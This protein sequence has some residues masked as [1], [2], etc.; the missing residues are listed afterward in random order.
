MHK[1]Y[2]VAASSLAPSH[3][4]RNY[5]LLM[6]AASLIFVLSE[7]LPAAAQN[8]KNIVSKWNSV[9]LN[10][11]ILNKS[12][13]FENTRQIALLNLS[14]YD[15]IEAVEQKHELFDVKIAPVPDAS[16]EAAAVA[17]GYTVLS[18]LFPQDNGTNLSS[19]Y[20]HEL[21]R[22]PDGQAKS[23]G[24]A[25]GVEVAKQLLGDRKDDG[26]GDQ[27][28]NYSEIQPF[29]LSRPDQFPLPPPPART[30]AE[31]SADINQ[32]KDL[33]ER[34]SKVRTPD[35]TEI[36][37]FWS[38]T[39]VGTYGSAGH[40]TRVAQIIADQKNLSNAEEARLLALVG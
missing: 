1:S 11:I 6:V 31:Y 3:P 30:S 13:P 19:T 39:G 28:K 25:L 16:A 10:E 32:S 27:F 29:A 8:Q 38:N 12:A 21:S 33:G 4:P 24:I 37:L 2:S 34:D 18:G 22:I 7:T 36:A 5:P 17:A 40:F 26:T 23:K 9:L 15:A 14:L 35:Q 20:Y